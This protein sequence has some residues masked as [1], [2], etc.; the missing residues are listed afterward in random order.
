MI[1]DQ[2]PQFGLAVMVI[3]RATQH[4]LGP[5]CDFR[6][7]RLT[8]AARHSQPANDRLHRCFARRHQHAIGCRR[9]SKMVIARSA[10]TRTVD[11][12]GNGQSYI[13]VAWPSSN[14][15]TMV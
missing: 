6:V 11:S 1:V 14:G 8:P 7:K 2:H 10:M 5:G 3:K 12:T 13:V 15:P 9:G 4:P